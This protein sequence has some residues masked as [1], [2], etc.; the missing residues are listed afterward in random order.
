M[1]MYLTICPKCGTQVHDLGSSVYP[2]KFPLEKCCWCKY[3]TKEADR[4]LHPDQKFHDSFA[5]RIMRVLMTVGESY[6]DCT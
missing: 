6:E 4:Q 3:Q 5:A 1:R 2:M